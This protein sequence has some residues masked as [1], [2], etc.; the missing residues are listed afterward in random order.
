MDHRAIEQGRPMPYVAKRI[1]SRRSCRI[2]PATR[3][4]TEYPHSSHS[5]LVTSRGSL[6]FLATQSKQSFG[7]QNPNTP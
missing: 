5:L 4:P 1:R 6:R 7:L 2:L 3:R